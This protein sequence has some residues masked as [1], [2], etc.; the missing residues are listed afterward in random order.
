MI[1]RRA[2]RATVKDVLPNSARP[3]ARGHGCRARCSQP[4]VFRPRPQSHGPPFPSRHIAPRRWPRPRAAVAPRPP[5]V[6]T[7]GPHRGS[8]D[9]TELRPLPRS[10]AR[11]YRT[12][13]TVARPRPRSA[14]TSSALRATGLPLNGTSTRARSE[15]PPSSRSSGEGRPVHGSP[16]IVSPGEPE[17]CFHEWVSGD[18]MNRSPARRSNLMPTRLPGAPDP[19]R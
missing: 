17:P 16:T 8:R 9:E 3:I 5:P 6:R 4:R 18:L 10:H 13:T 19:G 11:T 14:A 2:L 7:G 12:H 15:P 1:G